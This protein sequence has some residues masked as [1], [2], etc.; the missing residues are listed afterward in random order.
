MFKLL[1]Y[2]ARFQSMRGSVVQLPSW[3]RL[4]IFIVALPGALLIGLSIVALL[5]S[6]SALLLPTVPLYRLLKAVCGGS[7]AVPAGSAFVDEVIDAPFS[8]PASAGRRHVEVKI[9][10]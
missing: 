4:L 8:A 2:F 9:V 6:I 10:E 5:V 3:A 7:S 1:E